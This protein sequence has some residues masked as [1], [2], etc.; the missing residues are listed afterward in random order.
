MVKDTIP[1]APSKSWA[2]SLLAKARASMQF[3]K[4]KKLD[5]IMAL[6]AAKGHGGQK[7]AIVSRDVELLLH[8]S[9]ATA[10][11]Y[12][13][14]LVKGGHLRAVGAFRHTRYEVV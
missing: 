2:L 8:V 6:A 7:G 12:L 1:V 4:Q 5:E 11:R 14:A 13:E 3:K 10:T 9:A